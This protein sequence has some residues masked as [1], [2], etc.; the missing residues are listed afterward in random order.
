MVTTMDEPVEFG[1]MSGDG[2]HD[3]VIE[4]ARPYLMK[5]GKVLVLGA[6]EGAL[7]SKL[8]ANGVRPSNIQAMDMDPANYKLKSVNCAFCDL[9]KDFPVQTASF[10][11]CFATEVI[12]HLKNPHNLIEE[13]HRVLKPGGMLFLSTPNVHSVMQK[14]RYALSDNLGWFY[15]ADF[16]GSGHLHPIFDWLLERMTRGKF[17]RVKY[18]SQTFHLRLVPYLPSIPMWNSRLF[19]V[20]NIYAF[21]RLP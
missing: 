18:T 10:D 21:R 20:N 17:E 2:V 5:D 9:N 4:I 1:A 11:N 12:E 7:E 16:L 8:I 15:E 13:A 6:G 19:A 3:K 14:I